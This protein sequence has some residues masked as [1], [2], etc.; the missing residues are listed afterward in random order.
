MYPPVIQFDARLHEHEEDQ[1]APCPRLRHGLILIGSSGGSTA[2]LLAAR[3]LKE[4]S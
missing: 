2:G 3:Y 4:A 1:A